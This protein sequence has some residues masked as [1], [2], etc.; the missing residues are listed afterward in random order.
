M[1]RFALMLSFTWFFNTPLFPLVFRW[2]HF[3]GAL[4]DGLKFTTPYKVEHRWYTVNITS[5]DRN[6]LEEVNAP[7]GRKHGS[8]H[9]TNTCITRTCVWHSTVSG[10]AMWGEQTLTDFLSLFSSYVT[11]LKKMTQCINSILKWLQ[12]TLGKMTHGTIYSK[13]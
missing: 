2:I 9:C 4:R 12:W 1:V 3:S 6:A 13:H 10:R 7:V 11:Q 8:Y 5:Q